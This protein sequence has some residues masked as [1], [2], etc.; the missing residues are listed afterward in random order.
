MSSDPQTPLELRA[1]GKAM[2]LVLLGKRN[3]DLY[4]QQAALGGLLG[5][6]C[7]GWPGGN[8]D[9]LQVVTQTSPAEPGFA[10]KVR[11]AS[12]PAMERSR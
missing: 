4:A 9:I 5:R 7:H 1:L 8:K 11:G 3:P 12:V 2:A 10:S 6:L